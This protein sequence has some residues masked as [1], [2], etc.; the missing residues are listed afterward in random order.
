M[1]GVGQMNNEKFIKEFANG[2]QKASDELQGLT[3]IAES[4]SKAFSALFT[5]QW[6]RVMVK[7]NLGRERYRRRYDRRGERMKRKK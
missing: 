3:S 2:I 5:D 7:R 4:F 6:M 1:V